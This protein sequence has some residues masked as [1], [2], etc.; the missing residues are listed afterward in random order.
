VVSHYP[1]TRPK[2]ALPML[3]ASRRLLPNEL[4]REYERAVNA[5]SRCPGRTMR[6]FPSFVHFE[7]AP[8]LNRPQE[9]PEEIAIER[10]RQALVKGLNLPE[11]ARF[12]YAPDLNR[13]Q[14]HSLEAAVRKAREA[15]KRSL[16]KGLIAGDL[17][18]IVQVDAPFGEWRPILSEDWRRRL[19]IQDARKGHV[20]GPNIDLNDVHVIEG[21]HTQLLE[22]MKTGA[23]GR[24]SSKHLASIEL[25]QWIVSGDLAR[26]IGSGK[27]K[28]QLK[29]VAE[30]LVE[31]LEQTYPKM[32]PL[33]QTSMENVIRS[34]FNQ[35]KK[36]R[37]GG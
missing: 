7:I 13:P 28:Y 23:Q 30:R 4:W 10:A 21:D 34:R 6:R 35:F 11:L 26:W 19:R 8:D 22:L 27:V 15:I 14:A 3:E 33:T 37:K 9:H 17:T 18:A 24:P 5:W 12:S 36:D 2:G 20:T 29:A 32:P 1:G 25:D 16:V 31:W